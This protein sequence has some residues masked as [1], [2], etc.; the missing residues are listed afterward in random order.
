MLK[1]VCFIKFNAKEQKE[2]YNRKAEEET[3]KWWKAQ[4]NIVKQ[5]SLY[6]SEQDV[7]L[8]TG[9]KIIKD[10][11][12]KHSKNRETVWTR[13]SLDQFVI[14]SV[15][16]HSLKTDLLFDYSQYMDM[17]TAISILKDTAK[18]GY[19]SIDNFD[20]NLVFKHDP[21]HDVVYD[22]MMLLYGKWKRSC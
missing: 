16:K 10:Y 14:D 4:C 7:S 11:V 5:V 21:R 8:E 18:S 17:R 6:P 9:I 22:V 2:I 20:N 13:G 3:V 1:N 19:C 15:C 12:K